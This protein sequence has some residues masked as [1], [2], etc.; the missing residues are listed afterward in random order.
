MSN[1]TLGAKLRKYEARVEEARKQGREPDDTDLERLMYYA[2]AVKAHGPEAPVR[3]RDR[4]AGAI[5]KLGSDEV[6]KLLKL[7]KSL[8]K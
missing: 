5:S 1:S 7:A 6:T 2:G 4:L 3:K 8:R